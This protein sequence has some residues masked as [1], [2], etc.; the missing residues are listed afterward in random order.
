M[1]PYFSILLT[2][3]V[4]L[5]ENQDKKKKMVEARRPMANKANRDTGQV[6]AV[7]SHI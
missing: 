7:Q 6:A 4:I 1:K 5:T 2:V 3:V